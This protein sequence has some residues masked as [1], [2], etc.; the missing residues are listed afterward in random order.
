MPREKKTFTEASRRA[1]AAREATGKAIFQSPVGVMRLQ[2]NDVEM[3]VDGGRVV[4]V[5]DNTE[6]DSL[7]EEF[8]IAGVT[9]VLNY[10][11]DEPMRKWPVTR[12]ERSSRRFTLVI[13]EEEIES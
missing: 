1:H 2:E 9:V 10:R 7:F 8:R 4:L 11:K 12:T 6:S 13:Y 5:A 3:D